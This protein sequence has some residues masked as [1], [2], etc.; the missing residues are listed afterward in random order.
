VPKVTGKR[1]AAAKSTLARG[2]CRAGKVS[3][4]YS[5]KKKGLVSAQSRQ[6]GRILP[7]SSKINLVVSRG[8]RR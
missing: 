1:L 3:Y 6:P 7:A 8:P 2:H 4:A 5:A